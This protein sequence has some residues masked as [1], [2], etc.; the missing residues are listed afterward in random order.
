[1]DAGRSLGI[2]YRLIR[3]WLI[4]RMR[5]SMR[6]SEARSSPTGALGRGLQVGLPLTAIL[7]ALNPIWGYTW[8]F[9]TE[10]WAAGV[11]ELYVEHRTDTWR[12]L[13]ANAVRDAYRDKGIPDEQF[14][15]LEPEGVGD[16]QDFSFIVIG[17]PGEGDPSQYI[18]C[19]Q[20]WALG[21]HP[22]VKFLFVASDV[23]YPSG[24]MKDYE[25]KF[26]LPFKGFAKPIYAIPGNHDWYDGLEGF[27]ANFL[28]AEAARVSLRARR[29]ADHTLTSTT[30]RRIE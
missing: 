13:M 30:K 20:L 27:S 17:D 4:G 23:V 5:F 22:D 21:R 2:R 7:V 3:R 8:Y 26:Y 12:E 16:T 28:K 11:W 9:N 24:E 15:R 14:L 1:I 18:L 6:V 29:L 19:D 25:A 10:N